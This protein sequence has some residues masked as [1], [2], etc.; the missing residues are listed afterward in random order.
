MLTYARPFCDILLHTAVLVLTGTANTTLMGFFAMNAT[1]GRGGEISRNLLYHEMPRFF[2]WDSSSNGRCWNIR[3]K[4]DGRVDILR[5]FDTDGSKAVFEVRLSVR[6]IVLFLKHNFCVQWAESNNEAKLKQSTQVGRMYN[7]SP[8]TGD[9]YYLRTLLLHVRGA[10]SFEDVR[11]VDVDGTKHVCATY[12]QACRE[13][14]LLEDDAEWSR[15]LSEAAEMQMG[16]QLRNLFVSIAVFCQPSDPSA[17]LKEHFPALNDDILRVE[18]IKRDCPDLTHS[19]PRVEF[20]MM[21]DIADLLAGRPTLFQW[22]TFWWCCKLANCSGFS[23]L[24]C[25]FNMFLIHHFVSGLSTPIDR[26]RVPPLRTV[27]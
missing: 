15:C 16:P 8:A 9:V 27:G 2:T 14:G 17:L 1:S 25:H 20:M 18:R 11:T 3:A 5:S 6:A 22:P 24:R 26:N 12:Q 13:L 21:R 10:T 19:D 7:V 23:A 4:N